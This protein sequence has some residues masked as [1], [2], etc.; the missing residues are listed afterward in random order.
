M[1]TTICKI[2][3]HHLSFWRHTMDGEDHH[4][5]HS[6]F[7]VCKQS[8]PVMMSKDQTNETRN[9]FQCFSSHAWR[10]AKR[11]FQLPPATHSLYLN[12]L[13]R[14]SIQFPFVLNGSFQHDTTTLCVAHSLAQ[15]ESVWLA[16]TNNLSSCLLTYIRTYTDIPIHCP[17]DK[18]R[19]W[20]NDRYFV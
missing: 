4:H 12:L 1:K 5:H 9:P 10:M 11:S 7:F 18:S 17:V 14:S 3:T 8:F 2:N 6:T 20:M 15:D 19:W 13:A 16:S